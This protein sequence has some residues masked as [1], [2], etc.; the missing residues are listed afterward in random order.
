MLTLWDLIK[1][2][3]ELLRPPKPAAPSR[4]KRRAQERPQQ[5]APAQT[6]PAP[7]P[8]SAQDRYDIVTRKMLE[9]YRVRVRR[10]RTSMSGMAWEVYYRDGSV[11]R[12][13]ESPRPRGPMSAAIFLHEIGHHAIGFNRYRPRCLEEFHA[14]KWSLEAMEAHGLNITDAVRH[15]MHASLWYAV[16]KARRRGI[17]EVP[18]EL[19]PFLTRPARRVRRRRAA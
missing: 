3:A 17:R 2:V 18:P 10:W 4:T 15:R 9:K 11:S 14:W 1:P 19:T 6:T 13:I 12:R 7:A 8:I 5:T 16:S